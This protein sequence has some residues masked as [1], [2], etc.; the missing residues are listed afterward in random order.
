MK[1]IYL[2]LIIGMIFVSIGVLANTTLTKNKIKEVKINEEFLTKAQQNPDEIQRV[3]ITFSKKPEGYRNFIESLDRES[4]IIHDYDI[5][6]GIAVSLP[7]K[8]VERLKEGK[9]SPAPPVIDWWHAR[10]LR[11]LG[12]LA[13]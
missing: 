11:S 7:G 6:K 13:I 9:S 10:S 1:K 12:G 4:R 2:I 5:I 8:S 3:I